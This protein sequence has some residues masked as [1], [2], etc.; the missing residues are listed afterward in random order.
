MALSNKEISQLLAKEDAA[1]N[2]NRTN[3]T[4]SSAASKAFSSSLTK[5]N[6]NTASKDI[7]ANNGLTYT[8]SPS[9]NSP[10]KYNVT[11]K[12]N[13]PS[14]NS[15]Y[16]DKLNDLLSRYEDAINN[17]GGIS[18]PGLSLPD[19]VGAYDE[20]IDE[21]L[22]KIANREEFSYNSE[23][24]PLYQQYKDL[25]TKQGQLAMEDT[26]GVAAGLTGGYASSYSQAVGQQQYNAYLEKLTEMMPEFYDR[27]YGQYR[28]EGTDMKD[29]YGLYIDRDQVD[30]QRYQQEVANAQAEYQAAAAAASAAAAAEQNNISN[31]GNLYSLVLGADDTAYNRYM[32]E[33]SANY[34]AEQDKKNWNYQLSQDAYNKQQ[35]NKANAKSEVDAIL[36]AGGMP[37]SSLIS[38]SGVSSEYINALYSLYGGNTTTTSYSGSSGSNGS[39]NKTILSSNKA[40]ANHDTVYANQTATGGGS[41][42]KQTSNEIKNMTRSQAE[43]YVKD[44][45]NNN[46]LTTAEASALIKQARNS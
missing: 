21:L 6:T 1:D 35:T 41:L 42:Y 19:Y 40:T 30:F 3:S 4:K 27:A 43:A 31:L 26:M 39:D 34:Q 29:L 28:D 9:T 10:Y 36:E 12:T 25:Y 45:R 7:T 44:L 5:N 11:E 8:V 15:Q 16:T 2:K 14:Y 17:S 23:E 18:M 24:D 38:A 32:N 33:W 46:F 13:S 22:N 20:L 37:S